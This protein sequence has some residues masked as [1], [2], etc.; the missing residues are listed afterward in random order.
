MNLTAR[1][2][3]RLLDEVST[4]SSLSP[5]LTLPKCLA[6]ALAGLVHLSTLAVAL[7]GVLLIWRGAP[8]P[9]FIFVGLLLLL[10]A[11]ELRPRACKAHRPIRRWSTGWTLPTRR[12]EYRLR[13]LR[14]RPAETAHCV[15]AAAQAEQLEKELLRLAPGLQQHVL[16]RYRRRLYR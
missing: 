1:L 12:I 6:F 8:S 4:A 16:E 3:A 14:A 5:R 15:P 2:G 7:C 13:F 11:Y 9:V 10:I